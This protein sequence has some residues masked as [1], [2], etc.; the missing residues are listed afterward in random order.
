[1]KEINK[2]DELSRLMGDLALSEEM[3][4]QFRQEYENDNIDPDSEIKAN[5]NSWINH[6]KGE[7]ERLTD[8][9]DKLHAELFGEE[10]RMQ[11]PSSDQAEAVYTTQHDIEKILEGIMPL[12]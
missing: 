6:Y 3:L 11:I 2:K 10:K 9:I 8:E 12:E 5:A 4:H 1:M 7:V